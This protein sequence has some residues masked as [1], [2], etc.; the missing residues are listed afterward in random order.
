MFSTKESL[1]NNVQEQWDSLYVHIFVEVDTKIEELN[2]TK[3][4]YNKY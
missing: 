2:I 4:D 3:T 1:W